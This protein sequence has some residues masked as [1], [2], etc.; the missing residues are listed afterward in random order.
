MVTLQRNS[1]CGKITEDTPIDEC[2]CPDPKEKEAYEADPRG[3]TRDTEINFLLEIYAEQ[4]GYC[5]AIQ[6]IFRRIQIGQGDDKVQFAHVRAE[7]FPQEA[8]DFQKYVA[9]RDKSRPCFDIYKKGQFKERFFGCAMPQIQDKIISIIRNL[10]NEDILPDFNPETAIAEEQKIEAK[11]QAD[12][13]QN[14]AVKLIKTRD[15]LIL[16]E[17]TL[18]NKEGK[19]HIKVVDVHDV[20]SLDTTGRSDPYF[21]VKFTDKKIQTKKLKNTISG[22]QNE[23]DTPIDECPCPDPKDKEKYESGPRTK[24]GCLCYQINKTDAAGSTQTAWTVIA[25]VMLI[26]ILSMW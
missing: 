20:I 24:K 8:D 9:L 1:D 12:E 2:P 7:L 25:A 14:A 5:K 23:E 11:E 22:D 16:T 18:C 21:K 15:E 26:P 13:Y 17:K 4:C 19:V 10:P 3:T 6:T